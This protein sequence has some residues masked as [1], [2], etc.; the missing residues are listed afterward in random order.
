MTVKELKELLNIHDDNRIVIMS[1][2]AEGN[3]YSPLCHAYEGSYLATSTWAGEAGLESLTEE[4]I[5]L[6]Y[7]EE[8][9]L[10]GVP[11]LILKPIN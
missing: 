9:I 8:D 10:D 4:D 6:G 7:T 3:S 1:K 11:A 2:D 5:R